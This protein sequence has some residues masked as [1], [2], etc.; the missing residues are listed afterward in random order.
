MEGETIEV[1]TPEKKSATLEFLR[2]Y[3]KKGAFVA[4]IAAIAAGVYVYLTQEGASGET[5][6]N[7]DSV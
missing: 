1:L 4:G 2:K 5:G 3:W 6:G 7:G